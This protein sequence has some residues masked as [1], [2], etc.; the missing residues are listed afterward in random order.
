MMATICRC[1]PLNRRAARVTALASSIAIPLGVC[2]PAP[3]FLVAGK[4]DQGAADTE[5]TAADTAIEFP[6]ATL[7]F[8]DSDVSTARANLDAASDAIVAHASPS[9]QRNGQR[10]RLLDE[11]VARASAHRINPRMRPW[12]QRRRQHWPLK[13]AMVGRRDIRRARPQSETSMPLKKPRRSGGNLSSAKAK[14]NAT[15]SDHRGRP[16]T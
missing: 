15:W 13:W 6:P 7:R 10:D 3:S 2:S 4:I 8:A 12:L 1:S 9:G 5:P 16:R 11:V 14:E